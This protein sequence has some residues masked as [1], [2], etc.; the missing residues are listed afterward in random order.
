[1]KFK[2]FVKKLLAKFGIGGKGKGKGK[3]GDKGL[4]EQIETDV[5]RELSKPTKETD[6]KKAIAEKQA[7]AQEL[8]AR[9]QPKAPK[10]RTLKITIDTSVKGVEQDHDIDFTVAMSPAKKGQA[11]V[12]G[13]DL[14][15]GKAEKEKSD[16][17]GDAKAIV[18]ASAA[19]KAAQEKGKAFEQRI[20]Q[21]II[22]EIQGLGGTAISQSKASG[23]GFD[24]VAHMPDGSIVV[25]EIKAGKPVT[26]KTRSKGKGIPS[27]VITPE[28][29]ETAKAFDASQERLKSGQGAAKTVRESTQEGRT[30]L[31]GQVVGGKEF[32]TSTGR[33]VENKVS[34]F[35]SNLKQNLT[36]LVKELASLEAEADAQTR[37]KLTAFRAEVQGILDG[38]A[39]KIAVIIDSP[40]PPSQNELDTMRILAEG[41]VKSLGTVTFQGIKTAKKI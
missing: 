22:A 19:G 24:V 21:E 25:H 14:D 8:K 12:E 30:S 40:K 6:P 27:P 37:G 38:K 39:G 29:A 3:A 17:T 23:G 7:Q 36:D 11:P 9:F 41:A 28:D 32:V 13:A 20:A 33:S 16:A 5:V 26:F 34:A 31:V 15:T 4:V 1:M 2:K 18:D 10:G 35:T